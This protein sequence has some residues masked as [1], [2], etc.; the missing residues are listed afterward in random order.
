MPISLSGSIDSSPK[1]LQNTPAAGQNIENGAG[2]DQN[3][4]KLLA[5]ETAKQ[6]IQPSV[7]SE[8]V[9]TGATPT[10]PIPVMSKYGF[11][12][13]PGYGSGMA[14]AGYGSDGCG[15]AENTLQPAD[16]AVKK[17]DLAQGPGYGSCPGTAGYG[18]DTCG[19]AENT[20]Q[21]AD[22]ALKK[23]GFAQ[24]PG[25]RSG[26]GTAGHAGDASA[27]A[28]NTLGAKSS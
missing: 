18:N 16:T 10:K 7:A 24:G 11:A 9:Q 5:D 17:Y 27:D 15:E 13:G 12:Q 3:F 28:E 25:Y 14:T 6:P 23:Y 4:E 22:T 26:T 2:Q 20:L 21:P 8:P 1:L 19:E